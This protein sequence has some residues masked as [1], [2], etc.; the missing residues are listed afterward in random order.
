MRAIAEPD[1]Q[2]GTRATK[3]RLEH[4]HAFRAIAI[5]VIVFGHAMVVFDWDASPRLRDLLSDLIDGGTVLFVF[6]A[7]YLFEH[8]SG[9]FAYGDYLRKKL[10]NVAV[11]YLLLSTPAVVYAVLMHDPA[12]TYPS[13][14]GHSQIYQAFW[15]YAKGGAGINFPLWFVPMISIYYIAAPLFMLFVRRPR[16]YAVLPLLVLVSALA[17]R[18]SFPNLQTFQLAAYFVSAYVAGMWASHARPWLDVFLR[19]HCIA[20]MLGFA[21]AVAAQWLLLDHHGN[22]EG[23]RLFSQDHGLVDW[24]FPQ[25]LLLSFALIGLLGRFVNRTSSVLDV[26]A[27]QSFSI[28][29][30]HA[31]CLFAIT[32]LIGQPLPA[33]TLLPWLAVSIATLAVCVAIVS[34]LGRP[35]G[36]HRHWILGS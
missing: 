8:L 5:V 14:A 33:G 1:P 30:L 28:F 4:L 26:L 35:L 25:K 3:S 16:L 31:Y 27:T 7:G 10:R 20:L 34:S 17:H 18:P 21:A 9:R 6:I 2:H 29:F 11:P 24:Q 13:V 15:F 22:Y 12:Q 19:K 36:T 23:T 32:A